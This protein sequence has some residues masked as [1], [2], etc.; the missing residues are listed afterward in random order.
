M[1][2][3]HAQ[4]VTEKESDE[5]LKI[6][7]NKMVMKITQMIDNLKTNTAVSELMIFVNIAK[8]FDNIGREEW[9]GFLRV[10]APFAPFIAEELWQEYN[11]Y[12]EFTKENSVHLQSWPEYNEELTKENNIVI[13]VQIN[14]KLRAEVE[15]NVEESEDSIKEK[16]LAMPQVQKWLEGNEVKKFI[17]VKGNIVNIVI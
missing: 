17:Y 16:V 10:L 9:S 2:L 7:Y 4:K 6:A 3:K 8:K 1:E 11:N 12:A 13:G 5:S 15:I 14:G